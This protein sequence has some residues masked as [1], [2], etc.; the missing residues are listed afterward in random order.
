MLLRPTLNHPVSWMREQGGL[1]SSTNCVHK[2]LFCD[3]RTIRAGFCRGFPPPLF[4]YRNGKKQELNCIFLSLHD[5][6]PLRGKMANMKFVTEPFVNFFFILH[7]HSLVRGSSPGLS[8]NFTT[9]E[10][11]T[12]SHTMRCKKKQI[13]RFFNAGEEKPRLHAQWFPPSSHLRWQNAISSQISLAAAIKTRPGKLPQNPA[14][15]K[16]CKLFF[17]LLIALLSKISQFSFWWKKKTCSRKIFVPLWS[18]PKT[19]G[20]NLS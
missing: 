5:F 4:P 6:S 16:T 7:A 11:P 19:L 12:L 15:I 13:W 10:G 1:S 2:T 18:F 14:A 20:G 8:F 3:R 9:E 17:V